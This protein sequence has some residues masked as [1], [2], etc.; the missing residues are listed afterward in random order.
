MQITS[1]R[2]VKEQH[3]KTAFDGEGARLYGGR[4]NNKGTPMVYTSESLALCSLEI[5]VHLLSYDLLKDYVYFKVTFD[6]KMVI[7]AKLTRGWDAIPVSKVSK[8]IGDQWVKENQK[9]V[10]KV[11]SVIIPDGN[12]YLLNMNHP[13]SNKIKM[14]APIPLNFDSRL[15]NP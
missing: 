9:P 5:F 14:S 11:P 15:R 3:S 13:E 6:S 12:N 7:D 1:Y 2:I 10:L 4:W 8:N